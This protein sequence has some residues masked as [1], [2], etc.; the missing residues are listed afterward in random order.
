[1]KKIIGILGQIESIIDGSL[2][3]IELDNTSDVIGKS[4]VIEM[5]NTLKGMVNKAHTRISL[6]GLSL[7]TSNAVC[8]ECGGNR[9]YI[10]ATGKLCCMKCVF[11]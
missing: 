11:S 4:D 9:L 1:M 7:D 3:G 10:S 6:T 2:D 8:S 5:L